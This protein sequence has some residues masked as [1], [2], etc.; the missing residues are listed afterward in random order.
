MNTI[1]KLIPTLANFNLKELFI[2]LKT[3]LHNL[4]VPW[5]VVFY[6]VTIYYATVLNKTFTVCRTK[7]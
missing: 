2:K 1:K 6:A 5:Y 3:K 7:V 4:T